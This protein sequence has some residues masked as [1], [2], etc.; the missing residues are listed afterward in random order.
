MRCWARVYILNRST[1]V[2]DL[3]KERVISATDEP[4]L[5]IPEEA[6]IVA[7]SRAVTRGIGQGVGNLRLHSHHRE[8]SGRED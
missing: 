7:G 2:Y 6:V 1:P 3:V 4:P 8:I 5:I